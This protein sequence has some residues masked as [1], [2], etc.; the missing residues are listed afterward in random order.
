MLLCSSVSLNEERLGS[1][2]VPEFKDR[3]DEVAFES[4]EGLAIGEPLRSTPC[5]VVTGLWEAAVVRE[6][7]A[8]D[9]GVKRTVTAAVEAMADF[10]S[11]GG[12]DGCDACVGGELRFGSEAP[13]RAEI[14]GEHAGGERSDTVHLGEGRI[15]GGGGALDLVAQPGL[16]LEG[17]EEAGGELA[18]DGQAL[19]SR[20][21]SGRAFQVEKVADDTLGHEVEAAAG[22]EEP[23][24][25]VEA[26]AK[27]RTGSN[28][29]LALIDEEIQS[30]RVVVLTHA[31]E[32]RSELEDEAGD[33][34]GVSGIGLVLAAGGRARTGGP[35]GV[36][37]ID[38]DLAANEELGEA[39]AVAVGALD[40]DLDGLAE[41]GEPVGEAVPVLGSVA[42]VPARE[43]TARVVEGMSGVDE[44]VGVD[45]NGD[46]VEVLQRCRTL[47]PG[48][49]PLSQARGQAP[50]KSGPGAGETATDLPRGTQ[51][52]GPRVS[53]RLTCA[54]VSYQTPL[55]GR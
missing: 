19:E 30:G 9:D 15:A 50:I 26:V 28:G 6:G 3:A 23:E 46:H 38:A 20:A 34:L 31:R 45:A 21:V 7:D 48:P 16:V 44:L 55:P 51:P 11:G 35:A 4:A 43:G 42:P 17:L 14:G 37:V 47:A 29:C 53:K 5:D 24:V 40:A 41:G 33:D 52:E 22:E 10:A 2:A 36:D 1:A 8:M 25:G 18:D 39:V 27:L 13:A 32:V 49:T 54:P 12:L